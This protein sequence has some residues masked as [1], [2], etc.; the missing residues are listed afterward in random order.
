GCCDLSR[1]G[2]TLWMLDPPCAVVTRPAPSPSNKTEVTE[3]HMWGSDGTA[4]C[5]CASRHWTPRCPSNVP[6]AKKRSG[7]KK[8]SRLEEEALARVGE[9]AVPAQPP[10]GLPLKSLPE[11]AI[12][13]DSSPWQKRLGSRNSKAT[14]VPV[15]AAALNLVTTSV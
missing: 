10:V 5:R 11:K 4:S 12:C 1:L 2:I 15:P 8:S 13:G 7:T 9:D 6:A 14:C 3:A